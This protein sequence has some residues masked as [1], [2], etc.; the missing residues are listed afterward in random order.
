VQVGGA[1]LRDLD[2]Q[3]LRLGTVGDVVVPREF[4][5]MAKSVTGMRG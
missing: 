2:E 1:E 5:M 4:G 3:C